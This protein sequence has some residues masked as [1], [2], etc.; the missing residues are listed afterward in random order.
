MVR[1][2]GAGRFP[3][4][5]HQ[6]RAGRRV[7]PGEGPGVRRGVGQAR[8]LQA[9]GTG[10]REVVRVGSARQWQRRYLVE[11]A[12]RASLDQGLSHACQF[13]LVVKLR[14]AH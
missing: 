1:I 5:R 13:K 12:R 9:R 8:G 6:K 10:C 3:G 2:P 14:T 11:P 4:R 7:R